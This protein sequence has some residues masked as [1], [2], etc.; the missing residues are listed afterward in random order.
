MDILSRF[1]HILAA[2]WAVGSLL[3]TWYVLSPAVQALAAAERD[4]LLRGIS[5]RLRPLAVSTIVLSLLTGLY[6][7]YRILQGGVAPGYHMAFGI[8]FLLGLHVLSMLYILSKPP[9]DAKRDAK[10]SRLAL[11]SLISALIILGIGAYLRT[12]H[13]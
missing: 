11:G 8:K 1:I 3:Y 10:R 13:L 5:E 6:N 9:G 4:R 7:F 2:A 12:L